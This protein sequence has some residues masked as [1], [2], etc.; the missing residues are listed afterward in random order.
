[1]SAVE[2]PADDAAREDASVT[3][4]EASSRD[5]SH[6]S[7][8]LEDTALYGLIVAINGLVSLPRRGCSSGFRGFRGFHGNPLL[9][10]LQC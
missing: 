8:V 1:M 4:P 10:F 6:F 3:M 9:K 7:T 5:L 2:I